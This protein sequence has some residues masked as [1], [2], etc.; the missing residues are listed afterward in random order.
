MS[1]F[2]R[3]GVAPG[4]TRVPPPIGEYDAAG[5][6]PKLVVLDVDGTL[7]DDKLTLHPRTRAA[8]TAAA[9]RL[10][11]ILATGRMYRSAVPWAR[12]LGVTEPLVCYQG[13]L[14]REL[15]GGDVPGP[16]LFEEDLPAGVA[17]RAIEIARAHAWHR[18]AYVDDELICEQDR[19]EAHFYARIAQVPI[20]FVDDLAAVVTGGSTKI[21]CVSEDQAVVEACIAV[22]S[23]GLGDRA[24][25]TRSM[26]QFVEMSS[27]RVNKA[28][29]TELVCRRAGL[30]LAD[31]VAVGDAP[32]DVDML[33]A[34]GCGVAVRHARV[35]VLAAADATCAPPDQGGV[36]D[37][38]ERFGLTG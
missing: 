11:V 22:M 25:V 26:E 10:P 29:A 16:V 14:V 13:A 12:R 20:R 37:V 32:N 24:R 28:S 19:P 17:V 1:S 27:P 35:E 7:I 33:E 6:V 30:S 21:V 18:Q 23:A 5:F 2:E 3:G 9:R 31:A 4:A 38:L 15:P 34:A 36:A 8:V